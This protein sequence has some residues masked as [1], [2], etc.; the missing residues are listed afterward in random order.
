MN[1]DKFG[2]LACAS[3][4]AICLDNFLFKY[5][6]LPVVLPSPSRPP[7]VPLG[8]HMA[9]LYTDPAA[10]VAAAAAAAALCSITTCSIVLSR[11][12]AGPKQY[13]REGHAIYDD[14]DV[15]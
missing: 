9:Q 5:W 14:D 2:A 12:L 6:P 15:D 10:A 8:A 11:R 7:H 4:M 1:E 13:E 3:L